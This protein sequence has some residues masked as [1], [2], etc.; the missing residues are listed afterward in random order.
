MAAQPPKKLPSQRPTTAK[1]SG[2]QFFTVSENK[3]A[4]EG[5]VS[6]DFRMRVGGLP[7][8]TRAGFPLISYRL[9][10]LLRA[11]AACWEEID[12]EETGSFWSLFKKY[13]LPL[14]VPFIGIFIAREVLHYTKLSALLRHVLVY[15]P[16]M[17]AVYAGYIFL[18][19]VIAEETA[20]YSGGRFS[21]QS[22]V[23]VAIFSSL[24][25]SFLSVG[26]FLPVIGAPL[27]LI[28]VIWHYRQLFSGA[29][30]LLNISEG[31][32]RVYRLSHLIVWMFIGLT[33]F[34]ALSVVSFISAKLGLVAI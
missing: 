8:E 5:K 29:R 24:V 17:I 14:L 11:D 1:P 27:V 32:Y 26:A 34:V 23:R 3:T 21:P 19:G 22:G 15:L 4:P 9:R 2:K 6:P 12:R 25:L 20:E 13:H 30:A 28:G 10:R 18:I 31:Y 7:L 33:V 16:G